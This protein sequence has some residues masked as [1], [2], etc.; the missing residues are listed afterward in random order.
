MSESH[1]T[2]LN[3]GRSVGPSTSGDR[4]RYIPPLANWVQ[5]V[6]HDLHRLLGRLSNIFLISYVTPLLG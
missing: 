2:W 3:P 6:D 1:L 5:C 4:Q